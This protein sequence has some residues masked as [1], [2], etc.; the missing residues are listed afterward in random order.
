VIWQVARGVRF[1]GNCRA[2]LE[3]GAPLALV[4]SARLVRCTACAWA[5]RRMVV[6]LEA[7]EREIDLNAPARVVEFRRPARLEG[8]D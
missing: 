7:E 8:L 1:C 4:T 6:A 3:V 2:R 5:M